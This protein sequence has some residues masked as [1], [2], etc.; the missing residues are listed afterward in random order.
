[1]NKSP[2]VLYPVKEPVNQTWHKVSLIIQSH[3]GSVQFPDTGEAA[4]LKRQIMA[5]K[6]I[7]LDRLLRLA[8]ALVDCKGADKDSV[9]MKN[10]LELV[11]AVS[12]GS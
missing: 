6:N 9:G 1:M 3:L 12:A 7:I 5:E 8:R 4:K 10:A 2:L 11:R